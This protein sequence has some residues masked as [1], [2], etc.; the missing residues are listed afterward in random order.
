MSF[1]VLHMSVASFY[2]GYRGRQEEKERRRKDA[3]LVS[4]EHSKKRK[5][6]NKKTIIMPGHE[7]LLFSFS[8]GKYFYSVDINN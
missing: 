1:K 2:H 7:F 4:N 3:R 6:K 5:K 8:G